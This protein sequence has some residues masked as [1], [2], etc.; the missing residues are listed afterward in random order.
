M[1]DLVIDLTSPLTFNIIL[2]D[3]YGIRW[4]KN[5]NKFKR[6]EE[7]FETIINRDYNIKET[8]I[9]VNSYWII[10]AFKKHSQTYFG[11]VL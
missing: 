7:L 8:P 3:I 4:I 5:N 10:D 9:K 6:M 11:K 1:L 2:E